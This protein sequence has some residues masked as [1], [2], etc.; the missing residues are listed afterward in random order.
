VQQA[1]LLQ[2]RRPA[3]NWLGVPSLGSHRWSPLVGDRPLARLATFNHPRQN[4][5]AHHRADAPWF[6]KVAWAVF[7]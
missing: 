4:L 6:G 1:G 2:S 3:V 5:S 7:A